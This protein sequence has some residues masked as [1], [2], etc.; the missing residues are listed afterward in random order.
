ML[1]IADF[2]RQHSL[3][4]CIVGD[5]VVTWAWAQRSDGRWYQQYG[6]VRTMAEARIWLGY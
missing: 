4:A 3:E 6:I 2:I 1:H 5:T